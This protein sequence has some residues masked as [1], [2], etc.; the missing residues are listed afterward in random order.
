MPGIR[1]CSSNAS[2]IG[3]RQI[4]AKCDDHHFARF[5]PLHTTSNRTTSTLEVFYIYDVITALD[6]ALPCATKE[7]LRVDYED[8][9]DTAI[10][11]LHEEGRYRT[12]IDIERHSGQFPHAEWTREDGSKRD[13]TENGVSVARSR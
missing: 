5:A 11:R 3:P 9:L 7:S 1:E 6:S 2:T 10:N 12:F 8:R 13:L 4:S